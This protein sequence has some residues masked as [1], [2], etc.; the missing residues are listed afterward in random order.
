MLALDAA[1]VSLMLRGK[2]KMTPHEAHQ[3]SMI[4]G[5]PILEVMRRAGIDVTDDVRKTPI[6]AHM[7]S[8]GHVTAMPN[9]THDVIIG[10]GDI[11]L[12][13]YAVQVRTHTSIK[14]GWLLFVSPTQNDPATQVDTLCVC[15][16]KTGEH[17]AGLL[18]KGYR[19]DS[20]NLILWPSG[21]TLTDVSI[22]WASPVLWIKPA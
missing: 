10:P 17:I 19:R 2:R 20:Q 7:D 3:I 16:T 13:T 11:P 15:A 6:A 1:A 4:L 18:R 21:E 22:A 14:D 5:V 12:G 9:G 8:Y